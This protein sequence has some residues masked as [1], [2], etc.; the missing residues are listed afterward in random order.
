MALSPEDR[1]ALAYAKALLEKPGLAAKI[2]GFIGMPI[3]K[4]LR[5]LPGKWADMV[6]V[7]T[8]RAEYERI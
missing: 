7:A 8:V 2:T 6:N 1:H 3:E 4:A 5:L